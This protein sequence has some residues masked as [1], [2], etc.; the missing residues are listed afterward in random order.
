MRLITFVLLFVLAVFS[1]AFAWEAKI[2]G[3]LEARGAVYGQ[4][5]TGNEDGYGEIRFLPR[6]TIMSDK[7]LFYLEPEFGAGT[8]NFAGV[9][10]DIVE[11][12]SRQPQIGL[13]E[14][15]GEYSQG[16]V[17]LKA[18]KQLFTSWSVTDTVSPMNN[19]NPRDM[20]DIVWWRYQSV[21]AVDLKIGG[22]TFIEAVAVPWFTPA[23]L[24]LPGA[25]W[26]RDMGGLLLADQKLRDRYNGQYA[27]RAGT[28]VGE[29]GLSVSYY[30]GYFSSYQLNGFVLTPLYRP[31]EIYSASITKGVAGFNLRAEA[32]Y[33][34]Q[35]GD[36][37]FI[38]YVFAAD[39][40]WSQLFKPAD[41]FFILAQYCGED[42][43]KANNP[44][45]L[46]TIDFRRIFK[47]SVM[48]KTEYAP[49][50]NGPWRL[51]LEG[52]YSFHEYGLYLQP[53]IAWHQ[54]KY[55]IKTGVDIFSG[56]RESFFGGYR[57]NNRLFA[58]IA[59]NF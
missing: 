20:T 34:N 37:K 28:T 44:T 32:G 41:L 18:G 2:E 48:A 49:N 27:L 1:S 23:K 40:Q 17:R 25:R 21:P 3:R 7:F 53:S 35:D 22:D 43:T 26:E 24:P 29:F 4:K 57:D 6:F 30:S 5:K 45:G 42:V 33:F 39:R 59:W 13:R 16:L 31:E 36:D 55:E 47:N 14:A 10:H 46:P 52:S 51:R 54:D 15:Y 12:D 11:N 9:E 50:E 56:P 58:V 8:K 38:Q 19:L